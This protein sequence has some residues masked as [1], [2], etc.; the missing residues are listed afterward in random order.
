VSNKTRLVLPEG[1]QSTQRENYHHLLAV[2]ETTQ[3]ELKPSHKSPGLE[4]NHPV[5]AAEA[6]VEAMEKCHGKKPWQKGRQAINQSEQP[7]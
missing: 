4:E 5:E 7:G 6:M 2:L 3:G 1:I